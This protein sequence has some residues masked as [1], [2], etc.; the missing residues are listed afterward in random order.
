LKRH[1]ARGGLER[2]DGQARHGQRVAHGLFEP[3]I[4]AIGI[5]RAFERVEIG[6]VVIAHANRDR[7]AQIADPARGGGNSRARAR[8][9]RSPVTITPAGFAGHAIDQPG[10][11]KRIFEPE[12]KVADVKQAGHGKRRPVGEPLPFP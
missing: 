3:A 10:Q 7:H 1:C 6:Q 5:E 4:A 9:V 12:V 11:R 2:H 8:I